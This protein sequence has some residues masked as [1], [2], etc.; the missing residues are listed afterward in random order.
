MMLSDW[1]VILLL[2]LSFVLCFWAEYRARQDQKSAREAYN[3][4]YNDAIAFCNKWHRLRRNGL[5]IVRA[6]DWEA[7]DRKKND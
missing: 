3:S 2:A 7:K 4:G 1:A 6:T 5:Y